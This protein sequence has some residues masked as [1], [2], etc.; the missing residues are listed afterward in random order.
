MLTSLSQCYVQSHLL[1]TCLWEDL[2]ER[3]SPMVWIFRSEEDCHYICSTW[4]LGEQCVFGYDSDYTTTAVALIKFPTA[5]SIPDSQVIDE[6]IS[7][8]ALSAS[9]VYMR[10]DSGTLSCNSD[11]S[12]AMFLDDSPVVVYQQRNEGNQSRNLQQ[13]QPCLG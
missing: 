9:T 12:L 7:I 5:Q 1:N 6:K 3:F 8:D 13:N 10:S 2:I 4:Q 11:A